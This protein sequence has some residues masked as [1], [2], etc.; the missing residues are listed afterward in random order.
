MTPELDRIYQGDTL[1]IL[2][3]DP[4]CLGDADLAR[5]FAV[6]SGVDLAR[7]CAVASEADLA[8]LKKI[9]ESTPNLPNPYTA[10]LQAISRP[11][12]TLN[13]R[14]WHECETAH[15][16]AGWT[17]TLAGAAGAELEAMVGTP[18]AAAL[19][20]CKSRPEAPLPYFYASNE[21][22]M[23]FIKARAN[24]EI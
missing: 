6:A 18:G 12:C 1:E 9:Q 16:L 14:A 23:A 4:S 8:R 2:G 21:A 10:I 19:I 5:L 7:I 15:C 17:V 22:A 13:M 20:L 11:G 24:E 3:T